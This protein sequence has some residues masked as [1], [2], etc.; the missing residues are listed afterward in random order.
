MTSQKLYKYT[1]WLFDN[2]YL[3]D[4][5]N[6]GKL[7]CDIYEAETA[8]EKNGKLVNSAVCDHIHRG[9][10]CNEKSTVTKCVFEKYEDCPLGEPD[11][12]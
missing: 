7:L 4:V 11:K 10:C 5:Y 6:H 3:K 1:E 2:G 9:Y 12:K 8:E